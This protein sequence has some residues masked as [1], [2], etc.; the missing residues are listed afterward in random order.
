MTT[1]ATSLNSAILSNI[2]FCIKIN[3]SDFRN[4]EFVSEVFLQT[5]R[6]QA[7]LQI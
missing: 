1:E 3:L 2:D 4:D 7:L 6:K 5:E